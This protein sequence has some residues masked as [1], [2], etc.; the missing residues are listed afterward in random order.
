MNNYY[1]H[2]QER[3][4]S[5]MYSVFGWMS[6]ALVLTGFAAVYL[7]S[8]PDIQEKLFT[9]PGI[10]IALVIAQFI[11]VITLSAGVNRLSFTT[12]LVL[13]TLYAVLTG[14]MLSSVFVVF[15]LGSIAATFFVA[16]AMFGVMA[17]YGAVTQADLTSWGTYLIMA[18]FGLIIASIV[19]FFLQSSAFDFLISI[20]GVIVFAA[21]TAWDAQRLKQLAQ[22]ELPPAASLAL[23]LSLYLDFINL[24]LYLLRFMGQKKD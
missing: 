15:T 11:L 12:A 9:S 1:V 24:F 22:Y 10:V 20:I 19:N 13:F 18:L 16:A 14:V 3:V 23:A 7:Y 17:I 5:L 6:Y 8:I 4:R 21:L 2:S